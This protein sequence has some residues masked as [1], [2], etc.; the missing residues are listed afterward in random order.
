MDSV[1]PK[2][3]VVGDSWTCRESDTGIDRGWQSLVA[4]PD[5]QHGRSGSTARQ[6]ATDQ[7]AILSCALSSIECGDTVI[8]SLVGNDIRRAGDD[9][10]ITV[11]EIAKA[12]LDLHAVARAFSNN[13]ARLSFLL[14]TDPFNNQ[15]DKARAGVALMN[16]LIRGV[17]FMFGA[18]IIDT[19]KILTRPEHFDGVDFHPTASGHQA[20]ADYINNRLH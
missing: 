12:S 14:Y 5:N 11:S 16:T 17:A 1:A 7:G 8:I 2:K 19:G 15:D 18:S 13:G 3:V 6:W 9:G 4:Q 20:I 10:K